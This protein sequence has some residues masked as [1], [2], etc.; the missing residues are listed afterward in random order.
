MKEVVERFC[1][2][3]SMFIFQEILYSEQMMI[4]VNE[5]SSLNELQ[6]SQTWPKHFQSINCYGV[7]R[8]IVLWSKDD[9]FHRNIIL[10]LDNDIDYRKSS[11]IE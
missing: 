10:C 8:L 5:L 2:H 6:Q 7:C 4:D 1:C 9:S 11:F 3:Q